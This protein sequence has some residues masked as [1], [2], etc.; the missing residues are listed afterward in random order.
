MSSPP[1]FHEHAAADRG[2]RWREYALLFASAVFFYAFLF[3]FPLTPFFGDGDQSI[4]FYDAQR[5]VNGDVMYRDFF[6]F[7][8]PA[9]QAFYAGMFTVFGQ[10]FWIVSAT[11]FVIG[12]VTT[13]LIFAISKLVLPE[14]LRLLPAALFVFFGFRWVGFDGSHRM[15]SPIFIL[16]AV[17]VLLKFSG[18]RAMFA[19]G[20]LLG[21]A[22]GFTQQRGF[23]AL[24]AVGLFLI[25]DARASGSGYTKAALGSAVILAGFLV[26]LAVICLPFAIDA[27]VGTFVESTLVYPYKYY[28]YGH[29][30]N[31]R[32]Y[33]ADLS[34]AFSITRPG[35]VLAVAPTLFHCVAVPLM[36]VA[37]GVVL[38]ARR[39]DQA[40]SEIRGIT[41]VIVVALA[42]TLTTTAPNFFRL[43][44]IASICLIASVWLINRIVPAA[45]AKRLSTVLTVSLVALGLF[46]AVRVQTNW[47]AEKLDTP[48]GT[49]AMLD[50]KQADRYK[51]LAANTTPGEYF[52]EVYE[53]F[54]Y[55]PLGLRNPTRFGQIWPSEYTRPEHVAEV[56]RHLGDM[57]PRLILWDNSYFV[58]NNER[59]AG[60]HTGPLADFVQANYEP[61]GEIYNIG[62][63]PVQIWQKKT[64]K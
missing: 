50:L 55:F 4:F 45:A 51:W 49:L 7:T 33:F 42:L 62:G 26:T 47:T 6:Q 54:V 5:I 34:A 63:K 18:I 39:K 37:A 14:S 17:V 31:W 32:V 58:P 57:E 2:N 61:I 44:Q 40:W 46:Q 16:A 23:V 41:L 12:L 19:A 24:I 1:K 11:V 64:S 59:A 53:P 15:F 25:L 43:F 21:A 60:D 8:F 35:D 48:A 52:F 30:N 36:T 38:M 13:A 20:V 29:P 27:G 9:T 3:E 10:K 56:V 22:A 28:G